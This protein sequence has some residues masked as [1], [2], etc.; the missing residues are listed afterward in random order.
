M[1][2][3]WAHTDVWA[4]AIL[5]ALAASLWVSGVV[6]AVSAQQAGERQ[7]NASVPP[8][9]RVESAARPALA[10]GAVLALGLLDLVGLVRAVMPG[11]AGRGRT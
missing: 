11:F 4:P 5:A 6:G 1:H 7:T 9:G 3:N 2:R 10:L 8:G